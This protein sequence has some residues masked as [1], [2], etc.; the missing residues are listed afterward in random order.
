[1]K[2]ANENLI[3][4]HILSD[5]V[6][7]KSHIDNFKM[8]YEKYSIVMGCSMDSNIHTKIAKYKVLDLL[9]LTSQ[10]KG[11]NNMHRIFG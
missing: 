9:C 2:D 5:M 1:M 6:I 8:S 3:L 10:N 11:R 4:K 7:K